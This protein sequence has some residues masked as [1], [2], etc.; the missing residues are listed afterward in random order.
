MSTLD[1]VSLSIGALRAQV[2][3]L[4]DLVSKNTD[5]TDATRVHVGQL[6]VDVAEIQKDIG[7]MRPSVVKI[8]RWEQRA[9]G[10]AAVVSAV[11]SVVGT[12]LLGKLK[13]WIS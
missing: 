11:V 2:T 4:A 5:V 13:G 7:L 10:I 1:E 3:S 6:Q 9:L 8:E 12:G